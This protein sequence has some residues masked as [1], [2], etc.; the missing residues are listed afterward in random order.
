[1]A[2]QRPA[3]A[4]APFVP[5]RRPTATASLVGAGFGSAAQRQSAQY[6]KLARLRAATRAANA[7]SAAATSNQAGEEEA[8]ASEPTNDVESTVPSTDQTE[9]AAEP[10]V[11]EPDPSLECECSD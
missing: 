8:G 10:S 4:P 7:A 6:N 1:M 2:P 11:F 3:P 5:P 9:R